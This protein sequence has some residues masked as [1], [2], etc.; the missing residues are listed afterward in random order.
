MLYLAYDMQASMG[1]PMRE[2]AR[3]AVMVCDILTRGAGDRWSGAL[4]ILRGLAAGW[5]MLSRAELTHHRPSFAVAEVK[6]GRRTLPVRE[7]AVL[8]TPF[9]TL[10][11]FA[12]D[13]DTVLP[14]VLLV[15]PLS[16]H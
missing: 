5:E 6:V 2:L 13:S 8:S 1:A 9:G 14:K 4:P 7:E 11:R 3:R 10:L 16:G 12:R 15:A